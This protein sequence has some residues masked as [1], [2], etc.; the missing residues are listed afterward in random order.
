[1]NLNTLTRMWAQGRRICWMN[2]LSNGSTKS[3][4]DAARR[5]WDF[6][7]LSFAVFKCGS[8]GT[9]GRLVLQTLHKQVFSSD[10]PSL[11]TAPQ[12]MKVLLPVWDTVLKTLNLNTHKTLFTW[13]AWLWHDGAAFNQSHNPP[14][15]HW[16]I[17]THPT[18][19]HQHFQSFTSISQ[20]PPALRGR[21]PEFSDAFTPLP[22]FCVTQMWILLSDQPRGYF[23][24]P[25][26]F[27]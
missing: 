7:L 17:F 25:Q 5:P 19:L 23:R 15:K 21:K 16:S 8:A 6:I 22:I 18:S 11:L 1:M 14:S 20:Q 2:W 24:G 12:D 3:R 26:G 27:L 13:I 4:V 9:Y 10:L